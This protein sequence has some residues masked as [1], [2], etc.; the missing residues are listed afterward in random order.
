M[1]FTFFKTLSK[2]GGAFNGELKC[3]LQNGVYSVRR[4]LKISNI[5]QHTETL[6]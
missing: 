6:I 2:T 4:K 1:Q 3:M 5:F